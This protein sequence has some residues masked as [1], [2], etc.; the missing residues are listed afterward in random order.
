MSGSPCELCERPGGVLIATSPR[1]RVIRV[2]DADFPAF[3][4][5]VWNA[6]VAEFTDLDDASRAE[7]MEVVASVERVLR[8]RLRPTKINLAALGNVVPHLHWHAIARFDWDSHFPLPIW[9]SRQRDVVPPASSRLA[10]PLDELDAAVRV[11]LPA[12]LD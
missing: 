12:T 9:G 5:V 11:A 4:R 1:W 8:D 6:H 2:D 7:C 3:Y 10:L